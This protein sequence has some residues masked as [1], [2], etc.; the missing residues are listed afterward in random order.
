LLD[1]NGNV[2][3]D[4][5]LGAPLSG[6]TTPANGY[7]DVKAAAAFAAYEQVMNF[8]GYDYRKDG[9]LLDK[10]FQAKD[11]GLY[12]RDQANVNLYTGSIIQPDPGVTPPKTGDAASVIGFAMIAVAL[13]AMGYVVS[14]KVRA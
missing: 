8:F 11:T 9:V 14:R 2:L 4:A 13:A 10:H 1:Q 3:L 12:L 5:T 6:V 7:Y